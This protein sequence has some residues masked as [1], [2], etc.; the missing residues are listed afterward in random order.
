MTICDAGKLLHT[1]LPSRPPQHSNCQPLKLTCEEYGFIEPHRAASTATVFGSSASERRRENR[2][3]KQ[4]S[5]KVRGQFKAV[6]PL[7]RWRERKQNHGK[8]SGL[9]SML[10]ANQHSQESLSQ[11]AFGAEETVI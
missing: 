2:A 4:T 1:H 8:R 7:F 3:R 6:R 11:S 10:K 9:K 5:L